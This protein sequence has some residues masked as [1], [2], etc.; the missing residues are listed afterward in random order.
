MQ[1]ADQANLDRGDLLHQEKT[2]I[3]NEVTNE[4]PEK[5]M[6]SIKQEI[7]TKLATMIKQEI[8]MK[9]ATTTARHTETIMT[10]H[11]MITVELSQTAKQ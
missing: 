4:L 10:Q 3:L 8:D 6:K 2:N 1:F 9:L 7:D 5:L 11:K